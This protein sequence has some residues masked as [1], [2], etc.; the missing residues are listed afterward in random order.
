MVSFILIL[1]ASC[2]TSFVGSLQLGPVNL[3]V[4]DSV[5]YHNKRAAFLVAIGGSLPEFIYCTLAVYATGFLQ[6]SSVFQIVFRCV[7]I[8]ILLAVSFTFWKK[9]PQIL[10][11]HTQDEYSKKDLKNAMKGFSLAALNPQL[12]PFWMFTHVFFNSIHFLN[13][14]SA[15]L[16]FSFILGSGI[17]AFVFLTLL[18]LAVNKY[19][20]QLLVYINN[21]FYF[22]ALS[23]LFFAITVQQLI[24]FI[25]NY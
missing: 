25:H 17:G 6:Q 3:F 1:F 14:K 22:K 7:F 8:L 23:V 13:T 12:L 9:K 15:W 24:V 18:L 4:I 2:F 19:K 16:N 11:S 5:L 20:V 10:S 21:R